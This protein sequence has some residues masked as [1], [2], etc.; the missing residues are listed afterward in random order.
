LN[1]FFFLF[2][3]FAA[4]FLNFK[5]QAKYKKGPKKFNK[6]SL[7]KKAGFEKNKKEAGLKIP[8]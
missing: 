7:E 8:Y 1:F 4:Y 3:G 2:A 5:K 6:V